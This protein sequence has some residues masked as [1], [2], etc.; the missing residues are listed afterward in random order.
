MVS[1]AESL[2]RLSELAAS[3]VVTKVATAFSAA[4]FE[5]AL[6]G[7][8]VR[9][10]MLG[11]PVTDLDFTT[12]ASPDEILAVTK[13][14]ADAQW[15]IGRDFGTIGARVTVNG[16][17]E[18][19]E[20]T[21]YRADAYDGVTRK[22]VVAFGTNLEDDLHR[23]D[24][25]VNAMAFRVPEKVLVDPYGGVE[26]LLAEILR[27]PSAPEVSFGDDPLRMLRAARFAAQLGFAVES[28]TAAAMS[29]MADSIRIVSPERVQGELSKLLLTDKPRAGIELLVDTGIAEIVIP[30]IPALRLEID[31]HHHHK[32]VYQHSLTVLE[33]AIDYEKARHPGEAPDLTLRL[34]AIL[35]DIGKP[36]TRRLEPGGAVSFYHHDMVG[37]KLAKKRLTALR[38]DNDTVKDVSRLIELHL[39]FFGYT[40][41]AWTDSAVRR[42]VRDAGHLLERLHILT[43]ADVTTRNRRKADRLGFAYDDLE[44]RIAD[45]REREEM[46]SVR[47]DLDGNEIQRILG[48]KPGREVGE[49]YTWLLEL[50]LDEGPLGAE[51]A[52]R[53]LRQ[54]WAL[55][56]ASS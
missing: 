28:A 8:P 56:N 21:T 54:W 34:A 30:E 5:L 33:Q 45:L 25:T 18:T 23:R 40:D 51:E 26:D 36:A 6:V 52:E 16:V 35:H 53:R 46:E 43:R 13:P 9:D 42:Y 31:E 14:I 38:Y 39:R 37:S 24:F 20:I 19:V 2:V 11:R 7:G 15:D 47:P 55:R 50:R 22:P 41:G 27:T 48:I 10:A 12:N 29:D 4:G 49:A 1:M 32:D 17:T 3:P 44:A